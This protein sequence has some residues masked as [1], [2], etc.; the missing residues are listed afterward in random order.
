MAAPGAQGGA[1]SGASML[2]LNAFDPDGAAALD[3]VERALVERR[4]AVFGGAVPLFYDRPLNIVRAEGVWLYDHE[5]RR[6]LDAY[7]NVPVV[8]HCHPHVVQAIATQAARLNTHTRYL[9]EVVIGYAERLLATFPAPLA[10]VLFTTTGTEG[11]DLALRLSRVR[12]G[13]SGVIVTRFAYH[14]HSVAAAEITPAFGSGVGLGAHVRTV[15]AP[16]AGARPEDV[17]PAFARAVAQAI[18]DLERQGT[19][20]GALVLDS[21]LSSDGLFVDPPGYLA[22][23][24]AQARAA[25]GLFVADEVQ[26][27]FGRTGAGMWGFTRHGLVPDIVVMGKPMGNG[28]PIGAVVTHADILADFAARTGYFN[29]FGG[30]TVSCAAAAAVLDVIEGEGLIGSAQKVGAHL[31][32]GFT[33]LQAGLPCIG[34][35]RGAGLYVAVDLVQRDDPAAPDTALARRLINGLRERQIL[36]S[37][38]GPAGNV[39]KIRPPLPF[40]TANADQL[41]QAT[42]ELLAGSA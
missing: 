12:T 6:Y 30:N 15:A 14:G 29:T 34:A 19:P 2:A 1:M 9:S 36:I 17:G 11:I 13:R 25:G 31:K 39:L 20:L 27:G 23:A 40:S 3:P 18:A 22:E 33:Q 28:M 21:V 4:A 32:A 7:N 10:R 5:N 24:V 41:L 16:V 38:C 37:T 26:P 35:V 8:G 42:G